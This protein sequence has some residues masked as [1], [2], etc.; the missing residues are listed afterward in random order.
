[1]GFLCSRNRLIEPANGSLF[2]PETN[3]NDPFQSRIPKITIGWV[4]Y[5]RSAPISLVKLTSR[6][7]HQLFT[8]PYRSWVRLNQAI[9]STQVGQVRKVG[10][11]S[12]CKT[13][14][15]SETGN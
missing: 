2:R 9:I 11:K 6:Q 12:Y 5:G 15:P 14:L 8:A 1:M 7:G 10:C 4:E 13:G 3:C